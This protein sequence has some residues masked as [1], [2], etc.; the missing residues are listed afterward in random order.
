MAR[1]PRNARKLIMLGLDCALPHL[2]REFVREGQLPNMSKL[3][4]RGMMS[5]MI[6][7]FPPLTASAW[8]A[9][10]S[11]AGPGTSGIPSL[12]VHYPGEPLDKWYTSFDRGVVTAE[13]LWESAGRAGRQ[14]ILMNWPVTFPM[15]IDKGVQIAATLNPPFR[16]YYLPI[17]DV[18]S[19]AL[20]STEKHRCNQ[21]PGRA[22]QVE[23]R[24]A[25]GWKNLPE[26]FSTPLEIEI[27]VPPRY[28]P[29]H[30]Y[31]VAM[32]DTHNSGYDQ[33]VVSKT[34]DAE[35]AVARLGSKQRSGWIRDTFETGSGEKRGQFYFYLIGIGPG[36]SIS[37]LESQINTAEGYTIPDDLTQRVEAAAGVYQEVDDPWA[38]LDGWVDLDF[39]LDQLTYHRDWWAKA[40]RF[41][42]DTQQWDLVFS[43]VGVIDH[44]QHVLY[45]GMDPDVSF[46]D[47]DE[48]AKIRQHILRVY[49]E[50]D[51]GVG[52][53]VEGL[54]LDE[55][56]VC[57]VSDHGM[58]GNDKNPFL[59][60][61][62][63]KAGLLS[64]ELDFKTGE[65]K[66]DWSRTK[67]Y[68][69][70]PCHAHIFVN[71]K[72]R[73]PDG[74]V[75]P[76]DYKKVQEQII[77][78]L[79]GMRDP[80]TGERVVDVAIRRED[81]GTLGIFD[82]GTF[83][84]IGDVLFAF[85]PM[86]AANP[87]IYPSAVEYM[88]GTRRYIPNLEGYEPVILYENFSAFHLGLPH[89]PKMHATLILAGSG[90]RRLDRRLPVNVVDLAP[91]L[92]HLLGVPSPENA[93]GT[94]LQDILT[95]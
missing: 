89:T 29:G 39:Y 95:K 44:I 37:L 2:V 63:Q 76:R 86:Y 52:R 82:N 1:R 75:E 15:K 87:F 91:T 40:T 71:L 23:P 25:N 13:T 43:W 90:V 34:R 32:L 49:R 92:A 69:L 12:M 67:A 58:S 30:I 41:A 16:F 81:S 33:I 65:M 27:T 7:T 20:F 35:K 77:D 5:D 66:V 4:G 79:L 26:S 72:G 24:P 21:V 83:D 61:H 68:P 8:V 10:T 70:E 84:R 62:L 57:L 19:S 14:S 47:Q 51:E 60:H 80:V 59:K 54:D 11:G 36:K 85:K 38:Y 48:A 93:E 3:I 9:I 46:Y 53:I 88:D 55:V 22:V 74:I 18:A 94:V 50:V 45:G 78:V 17:W 31:H 64:Y 56:I 28:V 6:T 73:D 42:M